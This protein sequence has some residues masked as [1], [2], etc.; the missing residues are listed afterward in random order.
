MPESVVNRGL[1][2]ERA[3][4]TSRKVHST[5]EGGAP[6]TMNLLNCDTQETN[7]SFALEITDEPARRQHSIHNTGAIP[8]VIHFGMRNARIQT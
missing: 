6:C 1:Y 8:L 4:L 7:V 5:G 3:N 2:S